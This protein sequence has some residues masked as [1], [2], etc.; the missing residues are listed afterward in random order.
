MFPSIL[1][2]DFGLILGSF[3]TFWGPNGLFLGLGYDLK[4]VLGSTHVVEQLSSS[5]LPSILTFDFDLILVSFFTFWGPN[6][7]FFG[8]GK[9]SNTVLGSTHI[10]K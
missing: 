5:M 2:F 9:G 3:F 7:L 4:T 1:T 10:V 6:G 8:L